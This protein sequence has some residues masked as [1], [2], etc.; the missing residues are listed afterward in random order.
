MTG[1]GLPRT[2]ADLGG[3]GADCGSLS[4]AV[5]LCASTRTIFQTMLFSAQTW[6]T[7][8]PWLKVELKTRVTCKGSVTL[9]TV[10]RRHPR[11]AS[12][13]K[14]V[15]LVMGKPF[16]DLT[17]HVYGRLRV[18][19]RAQN[20]NT[21][22]AWK[23]VCECGKVA[24]VAGHNLIGGKIRSCGCLRAEATF[25]RCWRHGHCV[26]DRP[27]V[28]MRAFEAARER[29]TN[30]KNKKYHCYGGRGI[31][32]L[33]ASFKEFLADVGRRP[34]PGYSLD[35]KNNNGNYELGNCRWAT[36]KEQ[37]A[38]TRPYSEWRKRYRANRPMGV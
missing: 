24:T 16:R 4:S 2:C 9:A 6:I 15:G 25:R 5:I 1:I 23:C 19:A 28:E 32:F 11:L 31:R 33:Y 14:G 34:G 38:N 30:P 35:R 7:G 22:A 26:G 17:G 37:R 13:A 3:L 12:A 21:S 29:C 20:I 10:A 18:L 8:Y 27:S 36:A